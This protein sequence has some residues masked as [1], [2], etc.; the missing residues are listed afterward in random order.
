MIRYQSR[1]IILVKFPFANLEEGKKR[2]ALV[3]RETHV[4]SKASLVTIAMITSKLDGL[5]IEGDLVLSDWKD[6]HLLHPSLIRLSK[7]A[8][9][10][11]ELID[12]KLGNLSAPD[13]K[14]VVRIFRKLY[15]AWL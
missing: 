1:D 6:S 9:I 5:E 7:V 14:A 4:T 2:P 13:T 8:T 15:G 10:D 12:R 11:A 3:L